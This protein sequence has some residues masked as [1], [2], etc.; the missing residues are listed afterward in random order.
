[1]SGQISLALNIAVFALVLLYFLHS[2]ALLVLPRANPQLFATVTVRIAPA[3]QRAAALVSLVAMGGLIA[4]Q[5]VQDA[6]TL[7][8][9]SFAE[10]VSKHALTTIELCAMWSAVGAAIYALGRRRGAQERYDY[11]A[12]LTRSHASDS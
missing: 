5:V 1:V 10:R 7:S 12:A 6:E 4:L 11:Q 3:V 9:L 2:L 8:R